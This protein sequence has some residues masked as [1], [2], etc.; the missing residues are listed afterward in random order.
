MVDSGPD[1]ETG[2]FTVDFDAYAFFEESAVPSR[3]DVLSAMDGADYSN[4]I[5]NYVWNTTDADVFSM[6]QMV[7][8]G[9]RE[10]IPA[11]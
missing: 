4:F 6:T 10:P 3:E 11:E 1:A 7:I 2:G 5:I 8:F 9:E